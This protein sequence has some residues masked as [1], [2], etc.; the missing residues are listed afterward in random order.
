MST[1]SLGGSDDGCHL[2]GGLLH[3]ELN[4]YPSRGE[5]WQHAVELAK[6][7]AVEAIAVKTCVTKIAPVCRIYDFSVE[8]QFPVLEEERLVNSDDDAAVRRQPSGVARV[9]EKVT[10]AD[11]GPD[12]TV[13][14]GHWLAASVPPFATK[15]TG[16]AFFMIRSFRDDY[17][18]A[19]GNL[20]GNKS[21]TTL[22]S[23]VS[24]SGYFSPMS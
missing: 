12:L 1:N 3:L 10:L 11:L 21:G 5:Y 4:N 15:L 2:L 24:L 16:M 22:T 18:P 8:P 20:N 14:A 23:V 6:D 9:R 19:V 17:F 13:E 7:A